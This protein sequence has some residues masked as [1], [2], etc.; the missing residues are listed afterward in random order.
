MADV[1]RSAHV[2]GMRE[3]KGKNSRAP[4]S[5]RSKKCGKGRKR[6]NTLAA[7]PLFWLQEMM[8]SPL[9]APPRPEGNTILE[10]G[11]LAYRHNKKG[12]ASVLMVSK[13]RSK[14]WGIPKGRIEPHLNFG[15]NA[16]KEALEA[17]VIG[18]VSPQGVAMFRAKRGTLERHVY[19][20]IEV[21]VFLLEVTEIVSDWREK[22]K[23]QVRWVSCERAARQ[24]REPVL[25][26]LC[27]R[28][29]Q[30]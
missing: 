4:D 24:L 26:Q 6:K 5:I 29:S 30:S 18:R 7:R 27:H 14:K 13:K 16:A 3:A 12:E 10:S 23:R 28:L 22:G 9:T 17:G 19:Q 2:K 20:I 25:V 1:T 11:V 21:W 8:R 15:E